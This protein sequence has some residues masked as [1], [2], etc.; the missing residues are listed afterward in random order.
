[1][2]KIFDSHLPIIAIIPARGGSKS[3]PRKNLQ[4][5]YGIPLIAYSIDS[6]LR[7]ELIQ[8]VYVSTDD[9]E[10][11][12]VSQRYGAKVIIRPAQ[13]AT[14]YSRD[15]ELLQNAIEGQ[16]SSLTKKSLIVFLRPSHPLRNPSTIDAAIRVFLDVSGFNSLRSMKLSTEIPY[17]MWRLDVNGSAIQ[18]TDNLLIDVP[19]PANA[20]RQ[21]LP[22]TFYQDGYV[23][24]FPFETI[25]NFGNTSGKKVLPFIIDEFSHDIDTFQDLEKINSHLISSTWPAW[26]KLPTLIS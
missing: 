6:A 22:E 23:D 25:L 24:V 5:L 14:D 12:E 17:K 7:S 8:E 26:F 21:L 2:S 13:M 16:F 15:N 18:V 19:D 10:I 1:M 11:A 9:S 4:N 20:P 3:V